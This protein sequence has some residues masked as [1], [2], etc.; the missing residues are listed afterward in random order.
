MPVLVTPEPYVHAADRVLRD[1]QTTLDGLA[2]AE[3][4]R[5]L[6][7][8]GPNRLTPPKPASA[9]AILRDQLRSVVVLLLLAAGAFSLAMGD[10]VEAG[11]IGA[12]LVVNTAMGF[13]VELR[14]R[15]AMEG[16]L[17]M[18]VARAFVVREGRTRAIDA[19]QL[20]PGDVIEIGPGQTVPADGRVVAG[21]DLRTNEAALTGESLP[22]SKRAGDEL[23]ADT[24]LADRTNMVYKGTSVA[25]GVGRVVVTATGAATE[26]GRVGTL[27]G[28]IPEER[29][30][31]ERRLDA[32]GRRLVWLA[33]GVAA[34][35]GGLGGLQGAS[36]GAMLETAIALAVAAVPEGLPAV[37]TIAL[38]I[39]LRRMARRQAL[40]RRLPAVEALG[41]ATIVCTDK[42]KT[43]T[44]GDMTVVRAEAADATFDLRDDAPPP[45][46][47]P[48]LERL[49]TAAV[50]ASRPQADSGELA[51]LPA[52][53]VDAA[54]L[55][56]GHARGL[57]RAALVAGREAVALLPFSSERKLMASFHRGRDGIEAFVKGAPRRVLERCARV[58][59]AGGE[60]DLDA[61]AH[62]RL[63]ARNDALAAAGLR[64]LA[65]ADGPVARADE[66]ALHG[67]TF[68]GFVGIQDPPAPGVKATI[69]RLRDAG[70]RTIMITGDQRLTAC[71]IGRELGL[72]D[73]E[74]QVIDGRELQQLSPEALAARL[75][76]VGAFSRVSPED[77]LAIVRTLQ[78]RGEIVAMLGDG[79]NDA[80]ALKKADV[81]VAMGVRGTDV[82][83]DA[84][85]IVLQD[86]RFETI[87]AAVEE[88][89]VV[90]DN[91]RKFVFYLFSCN[92]AEVMVLL[93]AGLA[94]MP[95][96]LLPL[97]ILFLN[98][99]TDTFPA[100]ALAIEPGD[101]EVMRRPPRDPQE[102][103]LSREFLASIGFYAL[104]IAASTLAAY[105]WSLAHAPDRATTMSF[106]TLAFAQILHLGN[107]RSQ[108]PV[109]HLSRIVSNPAALGAVALA[110]LLQIAAL[111]I[112]PLAQTLDVTP[113]GPMEWAI[114]IGLAAVPA[115]VGQV[116]RLRRS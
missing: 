53:P 67:L 23:A 80:A 65:V 37:A 94:A 73:S 1:L 100:L 7:E 101:P 109:L 61:E 24:P 81:G 17:A 6:A 114:V 27:V 36:P 89:R 48:R 59:V 11:A 69:E 9:L 20:V 102:A 116:L 47:D 28:G 88:G 75:A 35:I 13:I 12:V 51:A 3:A 52:D 38:A 16:L 64:V 33:L 58:R 78:G 14:A 63:L 25:A 104:L 93:A 110:S 79:V 72:L 39:G 77:K 96:P 68:A 84:S 56:A 26:L 34:A 46:P 87:A 103:V 74:A 31:L 97:Q 111:T 54:M 2:D 32:L 45:P 92:L 115:V 86:D 15:R 85:A 5:R 108:T 83:K 41:S 106:M 60:I 43:L 19:Q 62:R 18:D 107:A 71:A 55:R 10:L 70:L 44:S 112:E 8:I 95:L 66:P 113:L 91:I 105:A 82:A 99:V 98:L 50:I 30:P 49:L 29:T 90:F 22:V 42:T 57:E 4:A 21:D 76:D 40:V